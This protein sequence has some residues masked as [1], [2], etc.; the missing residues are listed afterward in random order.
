MSISKERVQGGGG[1]CCSR[2]GEAEE[3]QCVRHSKVEQGSI[4][5][6][7]V[8]RGRG[9]ERYKGPGKRGRFRLDVR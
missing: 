1:R 7:E 8:R 2:T 5:S 4:S 3:S 6:G 9:D